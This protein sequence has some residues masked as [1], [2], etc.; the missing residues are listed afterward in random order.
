MAEKTN[1]CERPGQKVKNY[2]TKDLFHIKN[3][4]FVAAY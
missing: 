4:Y 3:V 1:I 2:L